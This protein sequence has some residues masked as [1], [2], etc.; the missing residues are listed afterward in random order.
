MREVFRQFHT[1][2]DKIPNVISLVLVKIGSGICFGQT[3]KNPSSVGQNSLV[4]RRYGS[5]KF[6][7]KSK[8]TKKRVCA[9]NHI[10]KTIKHT[11]EAR[12]PLERESMELQNL[13]SDP[14]PPT[15]FSAPKMGSKYKMCQNPEKGGFWN[16][17][18]LRQKIA[19]LA[20][21]QKK[22]SKFLCEH[23]KTRYISLR[24]C[25]Y[26]PFFRFLGKK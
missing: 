25:V 3:T 15:P 16:Y 19:H 10:L 13:L 17:N 2:S 8:K 21:L 26:T 24:K 23:D 4:V 7:K 14:S 1:I 11:V 5:A 20:P 12:I 6:S 22:N 9:V 18:F